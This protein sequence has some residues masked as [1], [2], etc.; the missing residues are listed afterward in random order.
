MEL[1]K[2][3]ER[4]EILIKEAEE[5]IAHSNAVSLLVEKEMNIIKVKAKE[6]IEKLM[7]LL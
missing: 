5:V 6:N 3:K 1:Q 4:K 7:R 2:L